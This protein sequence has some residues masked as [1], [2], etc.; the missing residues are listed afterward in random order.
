METLTFTSQY[1]GVFSNVDL[2]V[3]L[4]DDL[5]KHEFRHRNEFLS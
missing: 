3:S 5:I 2:T 4:T 1:S